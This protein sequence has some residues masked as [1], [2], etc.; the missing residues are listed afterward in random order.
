VSDRLWTTALVLGLLALTFLLAC[1][2][3]IDTDIWWHLKAGQMMLA[4]NGIPR[5]DTFTF[6]AAGQEWIDLHWGFQLLA[7]AVHGAGGMAALTLMAAT[8]ATAA[9]ALLIASTRRA[10]LP[11]VAIGWVPALLLMAGRFY[12]RPETLSLLFLAA[13][14]VIVRAAESR[15][16]ALWLLVPLQILWVN[17]HALFVL[18]LFVLVGWL[19]ERWL[20]SRRAGAQRLGR[21]TWLPALAAAAA[22]LVNP[23]TWR[24]A[25]FPRELFAKL[26]SD[27]EFWGRHI[28]EFLSTPDFI[29]SYGWRNVYLQ[30]ELATFALAAITFLLLG[31][32]L[33]PFRAL[34]FLGFSWLAWRM[35]R[36]AT[37]FAL[38]A[39][40]V[41]AWN[42]GDLLPEKISSRTLAGAR[43]AGALLLCATLAWVASGGF[44]RYAGEGRELGLGEQA[45]WNAH[46]AARFVAQTRADHLLAYNESTAA[47]VEYHMR[48]DQRVWCD[49][50]LELM[51][52]AVMESYYGLHDALSANAPVW[53]DALPRLPAPLALVLDH[54]TGSNAEATLIAD[55][56]WRCT[57]FDA[58]AAVYLRDGS[59]HLEAVDF[60]ARHFLPGHGRQ[61]EDTGTSG[62]DESQLEANAL[63]GIGRPLLERSR[64]R[65]REGHAMLLLAMRRCRE[66][67]ARDPERV[68]SWRVLAGCHFQQR[69]LLSQW[70]TADAA[71]FIG[72]LEAARIRA[73]LEQ[74]RRLKPDDFFVLSHAFALAIGTGDRAAVLALGDEIRSRTPRTPQE[75]ALIPAMLEQLRTSLPARPLTPDPMTPRASAPGAAAEEAARRQ[76]VAGALDRAITGYQQALAEAPDLLAARW[77]L[78]LSALEVGDAGLAKQACEAALA[79]PA[80]APRD[81]ARFTWLLDLVRPYSL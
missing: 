69:Q 3:T 41:M 20:R 77:G 74:A 42:L 9:V 56:T 59:G 55:G 67:L 2:P 27:Y 18:G 39:C 6:G 71:D 62:R 8:V 70:G 21:E 33:S 68:A 35:T 47:V 4:G 58:V 80:L 61:S 16:S 30:L 17:T 14:L 25:L 40:A 73:E 76:L 12:A 26:S 52:R 29:S 7:A 57:F 1:F 28:G 65:D 53:K 36:N 50:R 79:N 54:F 38:V 64:Y 66:S 19:L 46:D 23:Y 78:A 60:G 15:R 63:F 24:G 31:R 72:D 48:P 43:A 13:T 34:V 22:S 5:T 44:Y 45:F 51:P 11:F 49:P 32:R 37:P 75:R 81:R 10:A